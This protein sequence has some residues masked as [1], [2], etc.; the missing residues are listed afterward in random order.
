MWTYQLLCEAA[1]NYSISRNILRVPCFQREARD[2]VEFIDDKIEKFFHYD[3]RYYY[4]QMYDLSDLFHYVHQKKQLVK[5]WTFSHQNPDSE[6]AKHLENFILDLEYTEDFEKLYF[7]QRQ[8]L[9]CSGHD[10]LIS[11]E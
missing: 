8:L 11:E 10:H 2:Y 5:D 9:M 7:N 3:Y 1:L 6:Q 4:R